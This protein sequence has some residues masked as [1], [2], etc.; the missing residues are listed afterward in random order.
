MGKPSFAVLVPC[1]RE[2]SDPKSSLA[3]SKSRQTQPLDQSSPFLFPHITDSGPAENLANEQWV[4]GDRF[5]SVEGSSCAHSS[6][7]GYD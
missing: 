4:V 1:G 3:W 2:D 5:G 6:F 7:V